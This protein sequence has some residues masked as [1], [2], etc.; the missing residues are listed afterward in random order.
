M[1][2]MEELRG[3]IIDTEVGEITNGFL[4]EFSDRVLRAYDDTLEGVN[5][6]RTD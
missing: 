6:S 1:E 4:M 3:H 2:T 5:N